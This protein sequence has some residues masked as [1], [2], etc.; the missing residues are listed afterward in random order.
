MTT[1]EKDPVLV[2]VQLSGGN[3]YLNTVIPYNDPTYYD[4]RPTIRYDQDEILP[5]DKDLAFNPQMGALKDIYDQG[6]LAV[7]HG[8]GWEESTRSHFRAMDIWHTAEPDKV[9]MEG[10]LGRAI[11]QLDPESENPVTAVNV[12]YGLPRA[13]VAPNA[14]VASVA[15]LEAYGMLS[16][17]EQKQKRE[18]LLKRFANMY[19]P[20]IGSSQV[21][22]YIGQTGLDALKGADMLK[23]A[24][25]N[26]DSDI[27]YDSANP[28]AQKLRD[29]SRIHL[30]GL[31]TRIFY[32][33]HGGFDT[34]ASQA[35]NHPK[36]WNEVS[37]AIGDFWQD[38]KEHN[39][40]ENVVMFVFSEFGRR[41]KENGSGTDHG[42]GGVAMAIGSGIN[43]G[44]HGEY[45]EIRA[46]ALVEG[47]LAPSIDFRST[48]STLLED[49]FNIDGEPI[50]NGQFEKLPIISK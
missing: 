29:V 4:N 17:V 8:V 43:G 2:V 41:V 10:W 33:E 39:A 21:M 3:D 34:H 42:A 46:E 27:E 44:M 32:T 22:D 36:L 1:K 45:P 26:Y 35:S 38:I 24:P 19:A 30:A 5:V 9:G 49:F 20:A 11:R 37:T 48:Y 15:D 50:V 16:S 6:D 7:I 28:L 47:D 12:G 23:V 40:D 25:G 14:S 31:G 13:L 18:D